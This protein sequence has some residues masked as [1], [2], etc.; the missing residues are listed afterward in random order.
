MCRKA[1]EGDGDGMYGGRRH[2]GYLVKLD[3]GD[4]DVRNHV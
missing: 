1:Y 3:E 2:R 4:Q